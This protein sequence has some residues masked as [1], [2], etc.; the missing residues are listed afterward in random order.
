MCVCMHA[1]AT[2]KRMIETRNISREEKK[3]KKTIFSDEV[4][5]SI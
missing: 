2:R 5:A 3:N 4:N 1:Q